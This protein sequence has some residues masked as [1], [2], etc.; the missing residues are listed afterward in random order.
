[1]INLERFYLEKPS[2]K[3]KGDAF[4]CSRPQPSLADEMELFLLQYDHIVSLSA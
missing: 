2:P 1:M 4:N 3:A